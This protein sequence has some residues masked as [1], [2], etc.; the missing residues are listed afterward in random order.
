VEILPDLADE[1]EVI[2][3]NDGSTD[4]SCERVLSLERT[5][6]A[7]RVLDLPHGGYGAALSAGLTAARH[8]WIAF[9]DGDAQFAIDD[10]ERL[11]A[12]S[13]THR[14]VIGY[15]ESRAEGRLRA[16]NQ[17]LL[18]LWAL[19]LFGIP[20]RIRDINCAFKLMRRDVVARCLPLRSRGGIVSTEL[21]RALL[22]HEIEI[23]QVPVRHFK[24]LHGQAS[25]ARPR[26]VLKAVVES[27]ILAF[28]SPRR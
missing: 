16:T 27:V 15:R 11:V 25:G 1:F 8:E 7:V 21:I 14:C 26:V 6:S 12:R 5:H 18:K 28:G 17:F 3:V 20:W 4:D 2:V 22:Q 19:V 24:R 23:A 10:L 13:P 9:T